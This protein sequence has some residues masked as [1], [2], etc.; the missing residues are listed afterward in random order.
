VVCREAL[1]QKELL[2]LAQK[3]G[4]WQF[5]LKRKAGGRGCWICLKSK[6]HEA[7][8]LKRFFRNDA[9]RVAQELVSIKAALGDMFPVVEVTAN[10]RGRTLGGNHVR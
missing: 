5:D 4:A 9:E 6:C 7:K 1:P 2:R 3:E 8:Q 10:S